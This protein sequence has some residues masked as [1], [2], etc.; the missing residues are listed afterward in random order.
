MASEQTNAEQVKP[1]T[2]ARYLGVDIRSRGFGF[3][4]VEN[5]SVL[6]SGIR[7]CDRCEMEDCLEQRFARI[8]QT[9]V[10]S[11]VIM[12]IAPGRS[13]GPEKLTIVNAVKKQTKQH[14]VEI[15]RRGPRAIRRHFS[16]RNAHTKYEIAQVVATTLPELAWKLPPK[17]RLWEPENY[18]M[19][20]FD[21]AAAVVAFVE[22]GD[23]LKVPLVVT[24]E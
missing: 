23:D 4:V 7:R 1:V 14:G 21:A 17:R 22:S 10:P 8:L 11:V 2:F 15:V 18:R 20:I 3:V 6:D 12:R 19:S 13:P 16:Q 5:S 24:N 9:Y